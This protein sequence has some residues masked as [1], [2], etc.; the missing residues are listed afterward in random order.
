MSASRSP[1]FSGAMLLLF[2]PFPPPAILGNDRASQ[3]RRETPFF[4][5]SPTHGP[6]KTRTW[7]VL[8]EWR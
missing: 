2:F 5:V 7:S 6:K 8:S 3:E 4:Y 1:V